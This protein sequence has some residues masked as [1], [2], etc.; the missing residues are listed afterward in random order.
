MGEP[1]FSQRSHWPKP[2]G[3][4]LMVFGLPTLLR[5]HTSKFFKINCQFVKAVSTYAPL[6]LL[7]T[8]YGLVG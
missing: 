8:F 7:V 3:V 6:V 4:F 5:F 2:A 1:P